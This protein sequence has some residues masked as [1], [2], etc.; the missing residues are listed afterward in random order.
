MPGDWINLTPEFA[1]GATIDFGIGSLTASTDYEFEVSRDPTFATDVIRK[2]FSTLAVQHNVILKSLSYA[3][4]AIDL[5]GIDLSVERVLA[6]NVN[7]AILGNE[8]LTAVAE[9]ADATVTVV[10]N[11][12]DLDEVGQYHWTVTIDNE[13]SQA[14]YEI[15]ILFNAVVGIDIDTHRQNFNSPWSLHIHNSILYS[16]G[17]SWVHLFNSITADYLDERFQVAGNWLGQGLHIHNNRILSLAAT[18]QYSPFVYAVDVMGFGNRQTLQ[19]RIMPARSSYFMAGYEGTAWIGQPG[20]ATLM[21]LNAD[22]LALSHSDNVTLSRSGLWRGMYVT[23]DRFVLVE[24]VGQAFEVAYFDR[25]GNEQ[26]SEGWAIADNSDLTLT[27]VESI[28]S[29]GVTIWIGDVTEETAYAFSAATKQYVGNQG[30]P[31]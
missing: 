29:D 30:Q 17:V 20:S 27:K 18:S 7:E 10:F 24:K 4:T 21:G 23:A 25:Q 14:V 5:S 16:G 2:T 15:H 11:G 1:A 26:H 19:L 13:T 3:S 12:A 6:L 22:T 31:Q 9:D 28:T 8:T